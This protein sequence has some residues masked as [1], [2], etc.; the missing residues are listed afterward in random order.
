MSGAQIY[1]SI[2]VT[3]GIFI[4]DKSKCL[5]AFL[6]IL[7]LAPHIMKKQYKPRSFFFCSTYKMSERRMRWDGPHSSRLVFF[8]SRFDG[9]AVDLKYIDTR[10]S[11]GTPKLRAL[12]SCLC[13]L[14]MQ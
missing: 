5:P 1:S 7:L 9:S 8:V 14:N 10:S 4:A 6:P 2:D 11:L 13:A 3:K 12:L